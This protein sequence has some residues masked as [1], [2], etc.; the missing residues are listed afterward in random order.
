M[1]PRGLCRDPAVHWVV[2]DRMIIASA[3]SPSQMG[4]LKTKWLTSPRTLSL[5]PICQASG[6]TRRTSR[7]RP[8]R[9]PSKNFLTVNY[10]TFLA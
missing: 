2:G 6:L 3:A 4:R 8:S 1:T 5:L 9:N 7:V 10:L